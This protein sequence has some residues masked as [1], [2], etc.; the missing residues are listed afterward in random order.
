MDDFAWISVGHREDRFE[1]VRI[2]AADY[3]F[4]RG[5]KRLLVGG[6]GEASSA[7]W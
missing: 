3:L 1:V 2:R 6:C 7:E 4:N 5:H